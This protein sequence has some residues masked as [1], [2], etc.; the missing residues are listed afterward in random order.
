[1]EAFQTVSDTETL[2]LASADGSG[3]Y[4]YASELCL[5][6]YTKVFTHLH[7]ERIYS[8]ECWPMC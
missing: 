3:L 6:S 7:L 8:D 4:V 1:M 5:I 2:S